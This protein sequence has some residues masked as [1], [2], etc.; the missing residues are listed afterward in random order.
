MNSGIQRRY[1]V[2]SVAVVKDV[3]CRILVLG[4]QAPPI[5]M[6][7]SSWCKQPLL[8]ILNEMLTLMQL[9]K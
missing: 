7:F 2:L 4:N 6:H 9:Q 1:Q 8:R 5:L 3:V